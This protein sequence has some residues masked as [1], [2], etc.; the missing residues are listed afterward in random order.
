MLSIA[1][2]TVDDRGRPDK[3]FT[4]LLDPGCDPG[5]VHIHGLTRDRLK[6]SPTFPE[7]FR[8]LVH[9]LEGRVLVAH[10]AAF[11]HGFLAAEARRA[12]L[13]L[14]TTMR[15]CT[16]ALSRRLDVPAA[17]YQLGTLANYWGVP[18]Q[19]SHDA[20]DDARALTQVFAYTRTLAA[21]M[22]M[23]LPLTECLPYSG[24][25]DSKIQRVPC[26][27]VDAGPWSPGE[28]LRQGMKAAITGATRTPREQLGARGSAAGLD[29]MNNVSR[30]TSLLVCNDLA[31]VSGKLRAALENGVPVVSE[32]QFEELLGS[33][34]PGLAKGAKPTALVAAPIAR[35]PAGK[36]PPPRRRFLVL[37]GPPE[38]AVGL[39]ERLA[40]EG[41]EVATN[42]STSVTHVVLLEGAESDPRAAKAW[43]RGLSILGS[44]LL[45]FAEDEPQ[46]A[47]EAFVPRPEYVNLRRGEV[48][49]LPGSGAWTV[50]AL[51]SA[52]QVPPGVE[53][54]M[55]AFRLGV[56]DRA[57]G[58][59]DIVFF[60]QPA[61]E[62]GSMS[63]AVDG[64]AEQSVCVDLDLLELEHTRVVFAASLAGAATFAEVGAIEL[65]VAH[66]DVEFA[67]ATLDA[68]TT[69]RTL[70]LAEIY[71]RGNAWRVRAVGQGYDHGLPELCALY[72][73]D[74]G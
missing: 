44:D 22:R 56:D 41:D 2:L 71:R 45:P 38:T 23:P 64:S 27:W 43:E 62:D 16:L 39:R 25:L 31:E 9:M 8:P 4:T 30:R 68:A 48:T 73:I 14:P 46:P 7:V 51:W 47:A 40:A 21:R 61:A 17:N 6:G 53:V 33:V 57:A 18:H 55:L 58:D 19:N 60:N 10:N 28:P 12:G 20:L 66:D 52:E 34:A 26:P 29:M 72:G 35:K 74:V 69:E 42:L 49:D 36:V 32:S 3:E 37:G 5:P 59:E 11:D 70:V 50:R 15:L 1:A 24:F 54:D 13:A 65:S 67:R 63:L